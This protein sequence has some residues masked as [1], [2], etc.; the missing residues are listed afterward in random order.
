MRAGIALFRVLHLRVVVLDLL[1]ESSRGDAGQD[2]KMNEYALE[3]AA[4]AALK[5]IGKHVIPGAM[6]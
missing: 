4:S 1:A 5:Q 2:R 6:T 3:Q